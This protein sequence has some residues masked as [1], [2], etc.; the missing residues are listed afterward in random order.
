MCA[1]AVVTLDFD[2]LLELVLFKIKSIFLDS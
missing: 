2:T 1:D